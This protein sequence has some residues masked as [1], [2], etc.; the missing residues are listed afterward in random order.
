MGG[1]GAPWNARGNPSVDSSSLSLLGL[2]GQAAAHREGSTKGKSF[3]FQQAECRALRGEVSAAVCGRG[4]EQPFPLGLFWHFLRSLL[5][6]HCRL[7]QLWLPVS[8]SGPS[9]L[10]QKSGPQKRICCSLLPLCKSRKLNS[11][12]I[13]ACGAAA[14]Q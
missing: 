1:N 4:E 12:L 5:C 9:F 11:I 2:A 6:G 3:S 8:C 13:A 7:G 10:P 14:S